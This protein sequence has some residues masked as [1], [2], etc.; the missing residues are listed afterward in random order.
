MFFTISVPILSFRYSGDKKILNRDSQIL[1]RE[2]EILS[3]RSGILD[4]Q[5]QI[6]SDQISL[7]PALVAAVLA[8]VGV[9]RY[10]LRRHYLAAAAVLFAFALLRTFGMPNG[11]VH[12]ALFDFTI[13]AVLTIAGVGD[14]RLYVSSLHEVPA[15]V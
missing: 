15:L 2:P 4:D 14:H 1:N 11:A 8:G 10:P 6:L 9:H 12:T 3:C 7:A 13:S 5:S